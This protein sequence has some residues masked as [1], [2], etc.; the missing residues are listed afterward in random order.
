MVWASF[1]GC[2]RR[3]PSSHRIRGVGWGQRPLTDTSSSV[4]VE[5]SRAGLITDAAKSFGSESRYILILMLSQALIN[6]SGSPLSLWTYI[7]ELIVSRLIST[8]TSSETKAAFWQLVMLHCW[9]IG[10]MLTK[11]LGI[12]DSLPRSHISYLRFSLC[13]Q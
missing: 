13:M 7:V 10:S 11:P 6:P 1:W 4:G 9:A 3:E 5:Q 12:R 2:G 8:T